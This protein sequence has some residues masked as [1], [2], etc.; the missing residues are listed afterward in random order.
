MPGGR[1]ARWSYSS[2]MAAA[3]KKN[4]RLEAATVNSMEFTREQL[5]QSI[6][7][8]SKA[9]EGLVA[10]NAQLLAL[11]KACVAEAVHPIIVLQ[12]SFTVAQAEG[13]SKMVRDLGGDGVVAV[14]A[15][16]NSIFSMSEEELLNVGL[17]RVGT[18]H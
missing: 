3:P 11:A 10:R 15:H 12:G 16:G 14:V 8:L 7:D 5:V 2:S 18:G 13:L 4:V 6:L 1:H 17:M 9:Q